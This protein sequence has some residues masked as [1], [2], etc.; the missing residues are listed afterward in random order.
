M[1][2]VKIKKTELL[3]AIRV[4]LAKHRE[5]V[6]EALA[7]YRLQAIAQLDQM[8]ADAKEGKRIRRSLTLVEPMDQSA[9]YTSAIRKLEMS[10][11]EVI[12]ID[13]HSFDCLVLDRWQWKTQWATVNATYS[14]KALLPTESA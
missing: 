6:N 12:E 11:E 13:A 9:E 10:V 8:I 3:E 14:G 5:V 1:H 2:S 4:N 7:E